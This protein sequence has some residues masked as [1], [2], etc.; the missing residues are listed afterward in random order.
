MRLGGSDYYTF[1]KYTMKD[2]MIDIETWDNKA[3][4]AIMSISAVQFEL[5]SGWMGEIFHAAISLE[6]CMRNGL[7][8]SEGTLH[9]WFLQS[10]EARKRIV[11]A[12][13]FSLEE[14]LQ[15]FGVFIKRNCCEGFRIWAKSPVFDVAILK[16]AMYKTGTPEPWGRSKT[17]CV[18][19][20]IADV[21]HTEEFK[22]LEKDGIDHDGIDD[23]IFQ[24]KQVCKARELKLK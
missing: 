16:Y 6:S 11:D 2:L 21:E 9:W 7:T 20:E 23:C 22:A 17:R 4:S 3:S 10:D 24:I 5:T 12:P 1:L 13:K 15:W 18:R 19:T 14:A 8:V